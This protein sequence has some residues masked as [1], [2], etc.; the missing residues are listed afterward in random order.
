[1]VIAGRPNSGKSS[2]FNLLVNEDRSI[3]ADAPGT[4]RDWIEAWISLEGIPVGL[5]DTAGLR[6]S[7]DPVEQLGVARSRELID[8]ADLVLYL[9]D[10]ILGLTPEDRAFLEA[11]TTTAASA[12]LLCVWNKADILGF[13][14]SPPPGGE[15]LELSAKTGAGLPALIGAIAAVLE[16]A[17][18]GTDTAGAGI[19]TARQ[20]ERIDA[21]AAAIAEALADPGKPPEL[22]AS[23]LREGIN[24]LGEITGE[25]SSADIL[26]TMFSRFCVGK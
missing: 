4:T 1:V 13:S 21:A 24:A 19:G 12:P 14:G 9:I 8:D 20:K 26:E 7:A 17:C 25:V 16:A 10:G 22:I 15:P 3:V 5:V 11:R 2:L 6:N 23:L 18:R